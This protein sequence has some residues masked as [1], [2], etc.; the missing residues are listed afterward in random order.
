MSEFKR[1]SFHGYK[2]V[3]K[4]IDG[5]FHIMLPHVGVVNTHRDSVNGLIHWFCSHQ[6]HQERKACHG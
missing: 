6:K 4:R 2:A 5:V 3:Y 1:G